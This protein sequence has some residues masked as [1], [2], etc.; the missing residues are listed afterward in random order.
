M[1][2]EVFQPHVQADGS[3]IIEH[4]LLHDLDS[5]LVTGKCYVELCF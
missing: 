4:V 3:I 1:L 5:I 2:F